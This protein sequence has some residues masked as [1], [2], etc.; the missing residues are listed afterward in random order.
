MEKGRHPNPK[1][2]SASSSAA[3]TADIATATR[4]RV[5]LA[6]GSTA[7]SLAARSPASSFG[8]AARH[9]STAPGTLKSKSTAIVPPLDLAQSLDLSPQEVDA[10]LV[11]SWLSIFHQRKVS[12]C[13][14][15]YFVPELIEQQILDRLFR[16]H[17]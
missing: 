15:N 12:G 1:S 10:L 16:L 3:G 14:I 13:S 4:P 7:G 11:E 2:A 17:R 9:V 6:A 8:T 5:Q